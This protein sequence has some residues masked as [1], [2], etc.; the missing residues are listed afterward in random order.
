MRHLWFHLV[1]SPR[2]YLL[3]TGD[4]SCDQKPKEA[5]RQRL[6]ASWGFRQQLLALWNAVAP[7]TDSLGSKGQREGEHKHTINGTCS[8]EC[9]LQVKRFS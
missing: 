5:L 7:E 6:L 3:L 8:T 4:L 2:S 1:A 9:T